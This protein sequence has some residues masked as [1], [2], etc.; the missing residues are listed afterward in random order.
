MKKIKLSKKMKFL[1]G[2]SGVAIVGITL[3]V[4][5]LTSCSSAANPYGPYTVISTSN[6]SSENKAISSQVPNIK[7]DTKR[8]EY[9]VWNNGS[10]VI[11]DQN[12]PKYNNLKNK[13]VSSNDVLNYYN[14]L[15]NQEVKK[16]LPSGNDK[17]S[18]RK[19][20]LEKYYYTG[21]DSTNGATTQDS[22]ELLDNA[23]KNYNFEGLNFVYGVK[24]SQ[25]MQDAVEIY[26]QMTIQ[27]N[28]FKLAS[29]LS[30]ELISYGITS[31]F[32]G[33]YNWLANGTPDGNSNP[34]SLTTSNGNGVQTQNGVTNVVPEGERK[35]NAK[36][37][38]NNSVVQWG[39]KI[40]SNKDA[41]E[42]TMGVGTIVGEGGN[43]YHL[44]PSGFTAKYEWTK[45]GDDGTAIST[46]KGNDN[47][48]KPGINNPYP[49]N[50]GE[51]GPTQYTLKVTD[52]QINYQWYKA[53]KTGGD[54]VTY[55]Q[56]NDH[57]NTQQHAAFKVANDDGLVHNSAYKLP[58]SSLEFNVTPMTSSYVDPI[59]NSLIDYVYNGV[60]TIQPRLVNTNN[61]INWNVQT[62]SQLLSKSNNTNV[63]NGKADSNGEG[64]TVIGG[65][66][67]QSFRNISKN[68][69]NK[70][71][72]INDNLIYQSTANAIWDSMNTNDN[73]GG[74][75]T[76][77]V[78]LGD[79]LSNVP[80]YQANSQ[81]W[82]ANS[83]YE[84]AFQIVNG[85]N[86]ATAQ[87]N[88]LLNYYQTKN[89]IGLFSNVYGNSGLKPEDR[90]VYNNFNNIDKYI[91]LKMWELGWMA[92]NVN[93]T[94]DAKEIVSDSKYLH[95]GKTQNK[96]QIS[97]EWTTEYNQVVD[98]LKSNKSLHDILTSETKD[99]T[100]NGNGLVQT[101]KK[102]LE[103]FYSIV[104]PEEIK[105]GDI[106][107]INNNNG[108]ITTKQE[109]MT[110][111]GTT[112]TT[113][114]N[115]SIIVNDNRRQK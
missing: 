89:L 37:F 36:N 90:P 42:F 115:Q 59:Q 34:L 77:K 101:A 61:D 88:A 3:P 107:E 2:L 23:A 68:K 56:V 104:K 73:S 29:A 44:W 99:T 57:L 5:L 40:K 97:P 76:E 14:W 64:A 11:K 69:F 7:Y 17:E 84:A 49:I 4:A 45:T 109:N 41:I 38:A 103:T 35:E 78:E 100:E 93:S 70:E 110:S 80:Y 48:A 66:P 21:N 63:V 19:A 91:F 72:L 85:T 47:V 114:S 54:Y 52:I 81:S 83:D 86:K 26:N 20:I 75:N 18:D 58:I 30:T 94:D 60:Y 51:K 12:Y 24:P 33:M 82:S 113:P 6:N 39:Q 27:G 43:T 1:I 79:N 65:V 87:N 25:N 98:K 111:G 92:N 71:K 62:P 10:N 46:E 22:N 32:A 13:W 9:Y 105:P 50:P 31:E 108:Q 74:K 102:G 15:S 112:A 55:K 28:I 53:K 96:N 16:Q 106:Y 8:Q 67:W 95:D